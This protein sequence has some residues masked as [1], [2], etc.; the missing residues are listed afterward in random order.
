M[1]EERKLFLN[2][3]G[4]PF[5]YNIRRISVKLTQRTSY[6]IQDNYLENLMEDRGILPPIEER[7]R[8][9]YP[10]FENEHDPLLLDHVEEGY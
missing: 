7:D 3:T 1:T 6:D 8:F 4:R 2:Y 5:G 9:F 10:T